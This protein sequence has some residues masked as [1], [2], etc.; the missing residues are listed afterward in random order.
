MRID[1]H[2]HFWQYD[3]ALDSW[4]THSIF[5]RDFLPG[6]IRDGWRDAAIDLSIA[7]Q[8]HPSE[9]ETHFLLELADAC[10]EIAGVVGWLDLSVANITERLEYFAQ[11]ENLFGFRHI[12]KPAPDGRALLRDAFLRGVSKLDDFGFTCDLS[13]FPTQLPAAAELAGR[14]PKQ[15]FVLSHMA[16]PSEKN[17]GI[18]AWAAGLQSVAQ[19]DNVFC[20]LCGWTNEDGENHGGRDAILRCMDVMFEAFGPERLMFGSGWPLCLP[21][22]DYLDVI[23]LV[24]SYAGSNSDKVF[25]LN[26]ASFYD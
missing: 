11:F 3:T 20:K 8:A 21:E 7:V 14:F 26:A 10:P 4:I 13:V 6:E 12:A 19:H 1:A 15:R 17:G 9:K 22:M 2:Q 16:K 18:D 24:A 25:G 5:R 23:N